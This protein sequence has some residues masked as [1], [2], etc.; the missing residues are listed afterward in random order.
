LTEQVQ[1]IPASRLQRPTSAIGVLSE[2]SAFASWRFFQTSAGLWSPREQ[3]SGPCLD[4]NMG[5]SEPGPTAIALRAFGQCKAAHRVPAKDK[6]RTHD[7]AFRHTICHPLGRSVACQPLAPAST[8]EHPSEGQS[9]RA[10]PWRAPEA[11]LHAPAIYRRSR[12]NVG[13]PSYSRRNAKRC[14]KSQ[15]DPRQKLIKL[16]ALR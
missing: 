6:D 13:S 2:M 12:L 1:R 15:F 16:S 3:G 9:S 14:R 8:P 7:Q 11:R 4:A 5:E 10:K